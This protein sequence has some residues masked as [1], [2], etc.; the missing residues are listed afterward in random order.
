MPL[1]LHAA[2][3]EPASLPSLAAQREA[4]WRERAGTPASRSHR[5]SLDNLRAAERPRGA[6]PDGDRAA[7]A[8][9]AGGAGIAEHPAGLPQEDEDE[10]CDHT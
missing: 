6:S 8:A 1:S 4:Q 7:A 3:A 10:L 9:E 5:S 2:A